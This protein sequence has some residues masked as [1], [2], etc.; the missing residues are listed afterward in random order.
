MTTAMTNYY[1]FASCI[2]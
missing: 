2:F 1:H